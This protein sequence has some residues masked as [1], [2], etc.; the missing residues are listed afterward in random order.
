MSSAEDSEGYTFDKPAALALFLQSEGF[1]E[2]SKAN[3]LNWGDQ[4]TFETMY[5]YDD[6]EAIDLVLKMQQDEQNFQQ[7]SENSDMNSTQET[8]DKNNKSEKANKQATNSGPIIKNPNSQELIFKNGRLVL[9]DGSAFSVSKEKSESTNKKLIRLLNKRTM[10]AHKRNTNITAD[11]LIRDKQAGMSTRERE[12]YNMWVSRKSAPTEV[13]VERKFRQLRNPFNL[14]GSRDRNSTHY[15]FA[16]ATHI[17]GLKI[18]TPLKNLPAEPSQFT[19]KANERAKKFNTLPP[20]TTVFEMVS[21]RYLVANATVAYDGFARLTQLLSISLPFAENENEEIWNIIT[22]LRNSCLHFSTIQE[23]ILSEMNVIDQIKSKPLR[24][25]YER[26]QLRKLVLDQSWHTPVFETE[27][28]DEDPEVPPKYANRKRPQKL[29]SWEQKV[30]QAVDM[31]KGFGKTGGARGSGR[32]RGRGRGRGKGKGR[33]R[34][35]S[36]PQKT[37]EQKGIKRKAPPGQ[38]ACQKCGK[39]HVYGNSCRRKKQ[40]KGKGDKKKL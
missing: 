10:F 22:Q 3:F 24:L 30:I 15:R 40:K 12:Y 25:K 5:E 38:Y 31:P 6:P 26:Q 34:T 23:E 28:V 32:G 4:E 35:G 9:A 18:E 8:P 1:Q 29:I 37:E 36:T 13:V 19:K 14:E 17:Q 33:G 21:N 20:K 2:L 39:N 11:G 7:Q 16:T 27:S